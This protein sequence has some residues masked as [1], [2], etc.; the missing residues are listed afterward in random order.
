MAL[1]ERHRRPAGWRLQVT[2]LKAIFRGARF[3]RTAAAVVVTAMTLALIS[4]VVLTTTSLG[5]GPKKALHMNPSASCRPLAS[6]SD[7]LVTSPPASPF[8]TAGPSQQ[9]DRNLATPTPGPSP[10]SSLDAD[11]SG[12]GPFVPSNPFACGASCPSGLS[13][14][15]TI[16][17]KLPVYADGPGSGGFV[18]LPGGTFQPDP[19]SAV[20][21]PPGT[22]EPRNIYPG[23]FGTTYDSDY[24]KWLPV[25]Y[26]WVSPDGTR[27]AYPGADGIYVQNVANGSQVVLGA[28]KVWDILD[29][30]AVGVYATTGPAGGLWLLPFSGAV[31]QI[32]STGYWKSVNATAAYGTATLLP[33]GVVNT[34][35]KLDLSTGSRSEWFTSPGFQSFVIAFDF[36]GNPVVVTSAFN[37]NVAQPDY[38]TRIWIAIAPNRGYLISVSNETNGLNLKG[39]PIGDSHGLWFSSRQGIVL[40]ATDGT[41]HWVSGI[42][43]SQLAGGCK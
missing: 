11:V 3:Q 41:W 15:V 25:Q 26:S 37:P 39:T 16:S 35:L 36:K 22:A 14:S 12:P 13:T 17:C 31:K 7:A 28:G 1:G 24:S 5:C 6:N 30:E 32:T 18:S 2:N 8:A 23:W 40:Y 21:V 43:F 20:T 10:I 9:D 34:I 29:V 4:V 19:R 38:T 27:Y 33:Q 42:A